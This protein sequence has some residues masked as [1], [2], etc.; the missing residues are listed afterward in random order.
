LNRWRRSQSG[1]YLPAIGFMKW[2][3]MATARS[4]NSAH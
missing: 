2:S 4:K 1:S 3:L